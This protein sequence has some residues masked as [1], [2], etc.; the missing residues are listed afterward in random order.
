MLVLGERFDKVWNSP[1]CPVEPKKKIVRTLVEEV[2]VD[3]ANE[4]RLKFVI[5]WKGGIHTAFE[6]DKPPAVRKN[7]TEDIELIR[8]M[9]ER[10]GDKDIAGV[11]NR[12]G[13]R[14]GK[15]RP[16]SALAVKT[17]RRAHD[18]AGHVRTVEDPNILS[19]SSAARYLRVSNTTITRM[20]QAGLFPVMQVVPYAPWE[21]KRAD[22]DSKQVRGVVEKLKA[23]GRLD[24]EGG[25]SERQ[26]KLSE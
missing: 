9:A 16:W 21:I 12:L 2:V 8:K 23:T 11:L 20:S 4:G 18:I 19:F 6:M 10:F 17:A 22:L 1:A 26:R 5:H 3:R 24:L 25:S 14:T 15:D 13:R 7:A